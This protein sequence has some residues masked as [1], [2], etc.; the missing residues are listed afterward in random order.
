M[1]RSPHHASSESLEPEQRE[2]HIQAI[3]ALCLGDRL[4][5]RALMSGHAA[6]PDEG[7]PRLV[8]DEEGAYE[9]EIE[10]GRI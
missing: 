2:T 8:D 5:F 6:R 7:E 4:V 10:G 9:V 3:P 1:L